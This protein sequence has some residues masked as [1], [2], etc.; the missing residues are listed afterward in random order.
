MRAL[1]SSQLFSRL[2][3]RFFFLFAI[4][5]GELFRIFCD[6]EKVFGDAIESQ[7]NAPEDREEDGDKDKID[8]NDEEEGI[9]ARQ[10]AR[11]LSA[12][13]EKAREWGGLSTS[14]R[15]ESLGWR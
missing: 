2:A 5:Q 14:E 8:E 7:C 6:F 9:G 10:H 12:G 15:V 3:A 4:G 13:W 11:T 1:K